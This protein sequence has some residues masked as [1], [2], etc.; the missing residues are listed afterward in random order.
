M[1]AL[2]LRAA[3]IGVQALQPV[4][5]AVRHQ[6][7]ERAVDGGGLGRA[8]RAAEALEH[9]VSLDRLVPLPD[10]LEHPAPQIGEPGAAPRAQR[11]RLAERVVDAALMV[12]VGREI[13]VGQAHGIGHRVPRQEASMLRYSIIVARA[14][15]RRL[16]RRRSLP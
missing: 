2:R 16:H 13:V 4:H 14:A 5:Q 3:D 6:K 15:S 11:R 7:I 8:R 12:V 1:R 9:V 10:Q